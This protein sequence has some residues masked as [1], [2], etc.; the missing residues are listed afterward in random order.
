MS[1]G[2]R[3]SDVSDEDATRMLATCLSRACRASGFGE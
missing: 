3:A 2:N 1:H